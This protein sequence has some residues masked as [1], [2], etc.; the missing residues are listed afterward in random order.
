MSKGLPGICI[1]PGCLVVTL[2]GE[3]HLVSKIE[4]PID[5]T[6]SLIYVDNGDTSYCVE[7][8]TLDRYDVDS[9]SHYFTRVDDYF[10]CSP[11]TNKYKWALIDVSNKIANTT[12]AVD[13]TIY[14][15]LDSDNKN[16]TVEFLRMLYAE[17]KGL[18]E[19]QRIVTDKLNELR[20]GDTNA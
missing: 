18:R 11:E 5:A 8:T 19:A 9:I 16:I 2:D 15:H 13:N 1:K 14:S 12:Q 6:Y 20:K 7:R 10:I 3:E 4:Y 17:A